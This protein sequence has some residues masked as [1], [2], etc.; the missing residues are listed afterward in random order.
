M[1]AKHSKAFSL[2]DCISVG[3]DRTS[4]AG[5]IPRSSVLKSFKF[6]RRFRPTA[7]FFTASIARRIFPQLTSQKPVFYEQATGVKVCFW[8][9]FQRASLL[10]LLG[11]RRM[12]F[13][14]GFLF[15]LLM[16]ALRARGSASSVCAL[17]RAP[18]EE[19]CF[20]L[21][22]TYMAAGNPE[23]CREQARCV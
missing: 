12:L 2:I 16:S 17:S 11:L 9:L 22:K 10:L 1:L 19:L 20:P 7:L 18:C 3:V 4:Q 21:T 13:S 15:A 6:V 5:R 8:F 14:T 23:I